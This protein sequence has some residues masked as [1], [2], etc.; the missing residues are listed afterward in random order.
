MVRC[1]NLQRIFFFKKKT[2]Q[3]YISHLHM[4]HTLGPKSS[5]Y[6]ERRKSVFSNENEINY[7]KKCKLL[8]KYSKIANQGIEKYKDFK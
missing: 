2:M 5:V 1:R 6:F 4:E 3:N 8:G 7:N